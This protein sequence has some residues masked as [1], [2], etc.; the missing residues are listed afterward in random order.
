MARITSGSPAAPAAPAGPAPLAAAL[1]EAAGEPLSSL[2]A[3]LRLPPPLL[4][5]PLGPAEPGRLP[6]LGAASSAARL[7]ACLMP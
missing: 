3:R 1:G 7:A 6:G 5:L 4:P 2:R